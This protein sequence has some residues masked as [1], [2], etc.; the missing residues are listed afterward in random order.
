M[1]F[2][3]EVIHVSQDRP[4]LKAFKDFICNKYRVKSVND[5]PMS[6]NEYAD[7]MQVFEA[8]WSAR[9]HEIINRMLEKKIPADFQQGIQLN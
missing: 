9:E 4:S 3:V 2:E 6:V 8:G 1:T 5:L 7:L